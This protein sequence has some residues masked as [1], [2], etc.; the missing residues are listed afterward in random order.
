MLLLLFLLLGVYQLPSLTVCVSSDLI[1][2]DVTQ[3]AVYYFR[4]D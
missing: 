1:T 3:T 2:D 4:F